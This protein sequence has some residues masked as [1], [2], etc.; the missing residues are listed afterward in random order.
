MHEVKQIVQL[1]FKLIN[2]DLH[3]L[4]LGTTAISCSLTVLVS[5][6]TTKC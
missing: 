4:T 6:T 3:I 2:R 5:S 1:S